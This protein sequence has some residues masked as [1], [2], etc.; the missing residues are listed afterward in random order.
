LRQCYSCGKKVEASQATEHLKECTL[1]YCPTC[2]RQCSY[3]GLLK[4]KRACAQNDPTEEPIEEPPE[5]ANS[6]EEV[7]KEVTRVWRL[8]S[9]RVKY[10]S[11][12]LNT[13]S[14]SHRF[15]RW[16]SVDCIESAWRNEP[17]TTVIADFEY[18]SRLLK[19]LGHHATFEFALANA[20]GDWVV[21]P[22]T[23]NHRMSLERLSGLLISA[24]KSQATSSDASPQ[25]M[26][27]DVLISKAQLAKI[28]KET[29]WFE[30]TQGHTWEEIAQMIDRYTQVRLTILRNEFLRSNVLY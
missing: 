7:K 14:P 25:K 8:F 24:Q 18:D 4:H 2:G 29:G 26:K 17:L 12:P 15:P 19:Y 6:S 27:D 21:R 20:K 28:Y 9:D 1:L 30:E 10:S 11:R 5:V 23:I 16:T 13:P 22:T 3:A